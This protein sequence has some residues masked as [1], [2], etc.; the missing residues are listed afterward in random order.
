MIN[1][2]EPNISSEDI[3][4]VSQYMKSDSWIT[5]HNVTKELENKVA[6][7]VDRKY[8]VAVPN[9]TIAI[10]LAL[11]ASGIREGHKV[12]VPN[13]TMIATINAIIWAGAE[14]VIV[15]VDNTLCMSLDSLKKVP[16]VNAAIFVPLNGRAGSGLKIQEYCKEKDIILIEDSAHA[17]GSSYLKQKCGSLGILSI[18]SFTPHKIITMG[19]GGMVLL[20]DEGLYKALIDIKTFNR[21]KDKSDVHKGFGLN[22]KITDLQSS[23]GLSQLSK[24]EEFIKLK[25]DLHKQYSNNI[26]S[27]YLKPFNEY[28]TPWF[29]DFYCDSVHQKE[30][31][32]LY[33][34]QKNIETRFSYPSL[35]SQS[36]LQ[37]VERTNLTFSEEISSNILWLPS[38]TNL[39]RD[40]VAY[41][42]NAVNY[43][44]EN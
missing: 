29:V 12:A 43:F 13:I 22:F 8:A 26:N 18:F 32:Y 9:G 33:L 3:E 14:P 5:E 39:S 44:L 24:L 35:S 25:K 4:S 28:E 20:D 21:E 11:V 2:V 7:Y 27:K 23:L 38:S 40:D 31:L 1:Q 36:Y 42:S 41:V 17:L 6:S 10:Y 19:Q 15:D 30:E 37:N 34:K 16:E